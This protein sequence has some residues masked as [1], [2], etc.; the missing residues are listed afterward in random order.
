MITIKKY[1]HKDT[2]KVLSNNKLYVFFMEIIYRKY[3]KWLALGAS[4]VTT[5]L[6]RRTKR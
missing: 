2:I 3:G 1:G 4:H 6:R 5:S